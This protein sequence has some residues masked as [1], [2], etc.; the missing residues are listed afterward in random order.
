M[1]KTSRTNLTTSSSSGVRLLIGTA[2]L[3]AILLI[4]LQARTWTSADGSKTFEGELRSYNARTGIV[5]VLRK[6][7]TVIKFETT[8]LSDADITWV[9]ANA[10]TQQA[11]VV[12]NAKGNPGSLP[13]PDGEEADMSKPVQVFILMGQSN[14]LGAGKVAGP[15]KAGTLEHATKEEKLYPFLVDDTGNWTERKD[16]R[17]VRVMGVKESMKVFNNEWMTVKGRT[18]GPEFGIGHH[19][20]NQLDEPVMILKSCIGN[21]SLGWD[22]LPPGSEQFEQDGKIYAGYKESPLSWNKGE[23]PK[24]IGWYA[25]KQY[26]DDTANAKKVLAELDTYY[27]GAKGYEIAGFLWWQGA[28]DCGNAAHSGRYEQNLVHLIKQL[29]KDFDA[30]DAKFVIATLGHHTK[31]SKGNDKM[32]FDAQLAVD[33]ENGKYPEFKGKVTTVIA[34]PHSQGGSANGHYGGNAKTYMDVGLAMGEAM[35]ELLGAKK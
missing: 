25:G 30:P 8:K 23:A 35:A 29:R 28:K 31:A 10:N 3:S 24:P 6:N 4:P 5:S 32:V 13:D 33:G 2:L 22:L 12:G 26:D 19:I 18:I 15:D 7:G 27:P 14:M 1:T 21:R 16:V 34:N 11:G 9:A 17:N 20:G